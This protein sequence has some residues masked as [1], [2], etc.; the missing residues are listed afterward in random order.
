MFFQLNGQKWL[1]RKIYRRRRHRSVWLNSEKREAGAS[2]SEGTPLRFGQNNTKGM[3]EMAQPRCTNCGTKMMRTSSRKL[4]IPV[5][6]CGNSVIS[7]NANIGIL[8]HGFIYCKRTNEQHQ[9]RQSN[10]HCPNCDSKLM[11][12]TE[13]C[14]FRLSVCPKL[15]ISWTRS[16]TGIVRTGYIYCDSETVNGLKHAFEELTKGTDVTLAKLRKVTHETIPDADLCENVNLAIMLGLPKEQLIELFAAAYKLALGVGIK[17]TRG[18][19]AL[20]KGVG[21]RSR[22]ILD[23]IG[24]TFKPSDAYEWFKQKHRLETLTTDQKTTAWQHYAIHQIKEKAS[25]LA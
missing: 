23:N 8:Q 15:S 1:F 19:E 10:A 2:Q 4:G 3:S 13:P 18:I 25:A 5:F 11:L 6:V 14:G 20:C 24:I 17:P 12:L 7:S 22:L 9:H 21:R 16:V